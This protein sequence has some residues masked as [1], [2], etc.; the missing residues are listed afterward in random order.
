MSLYIGTNYHPHDWPEERWTTDIRLMK[1]A[2]FTTVRLGHLCWDSYEPEEGVYTFA[3]FDKVM[4]LFAEAKI[5]V[6]LD[7]SMRP[8]PV[9][10]HRLCPGCDIFGKSGTKQESLRRYMED[11]A[12]PAYQ[13]YAL[14]F[15]RKLVERYKNHPALFA[16]GLCNE[17]GDGFLSNS[18]Y[19]K[20]R[21]SE[22]L[23]KKYGTIDS[24]NRAW[25][26][27]RWSRKL[28]SF[29]DAV[30]QENELAIGAP[31][32]WLDMRRFFS[33]GIGEFMVKLKKTV[34]ECAPGI[35]HSSNH[36][37]EKDNLGFDYLKYCDSFVDYPGIGFY[38]G[39][40]TGDKYQFI[41]SVY[42]QRLAEQ[43]KPMWC[44]E[45]QSGSK[46]VMSGPAGALYMQAMLCLLNRTEMIL[47]WT[48]RSMLGGEEQYLFGLLGH[49][50]IPTANYY[51]YQKIARAMK[52]L[53]KYGFPYLPDPDIAVAYDYESAWVSQ[54]S[55]AQYRQSY[56]QNM[57]EVQKAFYESNRDYNVVDLRNLKKDYRLLMI[58]GHIV[59]NPESA[60]T[61]R[62]YVE[63]GG[64]VVMTGSSAAVD[65]N[66][67]VFGT[68]RPGYLDDVFGIR[69]AGFFRTDM[70]WTFSQGAELR[71]TEN[72][73]V[74]EVLTIINNESGQ[75][76]KID[77]AYY[78]ELE[79]KGAEA[80]ACFKDKRS[81]AVTR[82]CYG[83]GK[84]FYVAAESDKELFIWLLDQLTDELGLRKGLPVPE[85]IQARVIAGNQRFYVNTT[86][87]DVVIPLEQGGHGV[88]KEIDC[89]EK[90]V[91]KA[92]DSELIIS[93]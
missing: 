17:I 8:A 57:I 85:G 49:D 52:K 60:A 74:R 84:A 43:G 12:D 15:A 81:C 27:R 61:V 4:D 86:N 88:L 51:E 25:A 6:L 82:N 11:I 41:S 2:G 80:Y 7:V 30:I 83:K 48:W 28:L 22:W 14:R 34:E 89:N 77:S 23:K 63:Q 87:H 78:E 70:E 37:A 5:D 10:V 13:H 19:A 73:E 62:R 54:Y 24:L 92:Y 55:S 29:E 50:G 58:P 93:Q 39:Y 76:R 31:E 67:Q 42:M 65:E 71:K 66:G 40:T 38:P 44:L 46:G 53:E 1:E 9:W 90:L 32:A 91:L 21:F 75:E 69:I 16:F 64:T 72:G 59:M 68:P 33:D 35:P 36:Y 56:K 20:R 45:F 18:E 47:G 26:A 79:L 3:W